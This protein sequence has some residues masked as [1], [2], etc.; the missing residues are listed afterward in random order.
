[1]LDPVLMPHEVAVVTTADTPLSSLFGF[2]ELIKKCKFSFSPSNLIFMALKKVPYRLS[3]IIGYRQND[4]SSR[5]GSRR[6]FSLRY[7]GIH[8][9]V[10]NGSDM[11]EIRN[12][13]GNL[14]G[15]PISK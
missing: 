8:L 5:P 15:K 3:K 10:R 7:C 4:R 12:I 14:V 6:S 13:H 11:G 1:M 9:P 2:K